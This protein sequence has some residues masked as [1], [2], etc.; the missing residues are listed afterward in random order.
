M[1]ILLGT[2]D[3]ASLEEIS[4]ERTQGAQKGTEKPSPFRLASLCFLRSFVANSS[5]IDTDN[6]ICEA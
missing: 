6:L 1:G 5:S 4:R 3:A 2:R